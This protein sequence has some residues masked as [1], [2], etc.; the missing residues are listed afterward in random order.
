MLLIG[1]QKKQVPKWESY[2]K[3]SC[4]THVVVLP[5]LPFLKIVFLGLEFDDAVPE[6]LRLHSELFYAEVLNVQGLD[7]DG[8]GDLLLF[9][10]LFLGLVAF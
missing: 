9:F 6:L 7:T 1:V 10:E 4:D 2:G 5:F 3:R 8:E